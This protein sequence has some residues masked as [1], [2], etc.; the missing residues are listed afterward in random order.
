MDAYVPTTCT[1]TKGKHHMY[2][3]LDWIHEINGFQRKNVLEEYGIDVHSLQP[4]ILSG[5]S[6][7][8][9]IKAC[10]PTMGKHIWGQYVNLL[11]CWH[12]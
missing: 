8:F 9:C 2:L 7:L 1:Y 6:P 11:L 3:A 12:L 10:P 5:H 4:Y